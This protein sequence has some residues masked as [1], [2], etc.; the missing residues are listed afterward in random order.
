NLKQAY[1]QS[2][3]VIGQLQ[4]LLD[5][6]APGLTAEKLAR[7]ERTL[8]AQRKRQAHIRA[9][10]ERLRARQRLATVPCIDI[11]RALH[12]NVALTIDHLTHLNELD[13]GPRCLVRVGTELVVKR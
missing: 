7:L 3:Q 2:E 10:I 6:P 8:S 13:T 11:K 12:A 9:L 1:K 4:Q 5:S